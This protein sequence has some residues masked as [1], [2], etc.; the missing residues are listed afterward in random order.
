MTRE[1]GI[2]RFDAA[3][4]IQKL[5]GLGLVACSSG[6]HQGQTKSVTEDASG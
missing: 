5:S 6:K 4:E 2:D 3:K 1:E